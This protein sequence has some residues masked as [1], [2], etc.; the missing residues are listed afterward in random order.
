MKFISKSELFL[1]EEIV[2]KNFSAKYKDSVLGVLWSVLRPLLT[3]VILTIVFST[4]FIGRVENFPVYLLSGRCIYDFFNGAVGVSMMAIKGNAGILRLTSTKKYLFILAGVISEFINFFISLLLLL[5][6]M[7]ITSNPF[8]FTIMPF[9]IIPIISVIMLVTGLSFLFLIVCVYYSDIRHL[10]S[11]ISLIIMYSSAIFYPMDIIPEPFRQY[12]ILNP[13]YWIIEQ[14]RDFFAYGVIPDN[15][16]IINSLLL[17]LII[18][19]FGIIIYKKY[20]GNI[21]MKF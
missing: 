18:L 17:S 15:L 19:L 4:L 7:I 10:W 1:L 20:E 6:I 2:K 16:N 13:L 12:M 8:Y 21:V 9:S 14:F 5:V 3:M 11:A